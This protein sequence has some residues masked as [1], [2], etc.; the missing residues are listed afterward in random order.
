MM[1]AYK[2]LIKTANSDDIAAIINITTARTLIMRLCLT[3]NGFLFL[4]SMGEHV[5]TGINE[6]K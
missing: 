4:F 1:I 3:V 6:I 5:K 2:L